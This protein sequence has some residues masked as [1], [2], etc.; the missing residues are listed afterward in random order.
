MKK[1]YELM[2]EISKD[3][4]YEGL[5]GYGMFSEKLP[6][7]LTSKNFFDYCKTQTPSFHNTK[8]E[9]GYIF[10]EN[11]RNINIPRPLGIPNPMAYQKLCLYLHDIWDKLLEH[12]KDKTDQDEYKI[13]RIHIRK[14]KNNPQIF[15]MN[16]KNHT[17]D[18]T[19]EPNML[20]GKKYLVNADVSTCFPSI[21]SH[22]L[23]WAL[24]GKKIAKEK[25]SHNNEWFN[26]LDFYVRNTKNGETHGLLIG[27]HTSN[28]LSEIILTAIDNELQKKGWQ[29]I[30]NIDDYTCYVT[31]YEQG[32]NFLIDLS[33]E[34]RN[35]NLMINHKKTKITPLPV[36]S[37][38][39]WVRKLGIYSKFIEKDL[40]NFKDIQ[41][42]LDLVIQIMSQNNMNSA[43]L[44]FA[45]KVLSKKKMSANAK[46]YFIKTVFHLT[47]IYP[48]LITIIEEHL[49][50]PFKVEKDLIKNFTIEIFKEGLKNINYELVSYSL[51]YSLKYDFLIDNIDLNRLRESKNC[52]VLLLAYLY[53]DQNRI[54]AEIKAFKKYAR[55]L[56]K[57]EG[58]MN[59]YWLFVYEALPKTHLRADWK[60]LKEQ[61][62]T[63]LLDFKGKM[64]E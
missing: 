37:A 31:N 20:I 5:L 38:E 41:S 40:I 14:M 49:F 18:G 43:I 15:E 32:Q 52:I 25:K 17:K 19:P 34:L 48:Y 2:S 9:Q 11:M 54:T 47:I 64:Y 4:L 12:Y 30:R 56:A 59:E 44:N 24:V 45:I 50:K 61:G 53:S 60:L 57:D 33:K 63:F 26:M 29:Y 16:Y 42:Y 39:H 28:L 36:A 10:Y 51:Y 55:E 23:S 58:D 7:F 22:S 6:P 35:Y 1:Y 21:Y 8:K 3:K 46:D 62:I 13:S 27:P